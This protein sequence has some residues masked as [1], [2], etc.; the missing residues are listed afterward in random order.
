MVAYTQDFCLPYF[1]GSDSPCVDTGTVCDPSTVWC[2]MAAK[3]DETFTA[4]DETIN[5]SVDSFPYAQVAIS[6]VPF[7]FETG[8]STGATHLL[9]WDTV[10]GDSDRMV[11]LNVDPSTVT[12][13]RSGIWNFH[14]VLNWQ[15]LLAA[16]VI[17]IDI[18]NPGAPKITPTVS[19][20]FREW[21]EAVASPDIFGA[22]VQGVSSVIDMYYLVDVSSGPVPIQIQLTLSGPASNN[23]ATVAI[24]Q[25]S[26]RWVADLP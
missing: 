18:I 8:S 11:D 24:A 5:R 17:Q 7:T 26:A 4:F 25:F 10:V 21:V 14:H 15:A 12:I 16:S 9:I 6:D 1:E 19:Q 3:I 23:I 20:I 22:T 13:R 2:D